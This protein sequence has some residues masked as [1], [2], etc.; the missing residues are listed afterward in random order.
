MSLA[1]IVSLT[2]PAMGFALAVGALLLAACRLT[3]RPLRW[4]TVIPAMYLAAV[5]EIIALR[6]GEPSVRRTLQLIPLARTT[7]SALKQG[8]WPFLYHVLGNIVW[9]VPLGL[10]LPAM[11]P[12]LRPGQIVLAGALLSTVLESLQWLLASGM[13]DIDDV[14]LNALGAACGDALRRLLAGTIFRR[15]ASKE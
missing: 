13:T 4:K 9:F 1:G 6:F 12:R 8:A 7:L 5:T 2:L 3:G 15:R 14:L 11:K 10:L